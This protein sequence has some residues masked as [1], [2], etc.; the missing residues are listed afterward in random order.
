M[1]GM[2]H[3]IRKFIDS[4]VICQTNKISSFPE[5]IPTNPAVFQ[6][7]SLTKLDL[8]VILGKANIPI[9]VDLATKFITKPLPNLTVE[10]IAD[11]LFYDDYPVRFFPKFYV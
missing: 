6:I 3:T 9:I 10:K 2:K 8:C 1:V 7:F 4:C 5:N 11:A